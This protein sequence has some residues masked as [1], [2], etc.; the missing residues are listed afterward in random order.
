MPRN[1]AIVLAAGKGTRM[2]SDLPKVL[3][4]VRGRPMIEYVLDALTAGG[5]EQIIVV[6]GYRA[7]LVRSRLQDRKAV[8]FV[9]QSEQL[10]TGH[11]VMACHQQ[12]SSHQGPVLIVTGDSP[13]MRAETVA[14]LLAE[15]RRRPVACL[16]GT[17][18]K[19]DP[20]GLGRVIRDAK[21]EFVGIVEEGDASDDQRRIT[22]VHMSYYVFNPPD[23][24]QALDHIRRDNVQGEYYL[25]D[26]PGVLVEQGRPVRA[27]S[28]LEPEESLGVNTLEE[29][30]AVEAAMSNRAARIAE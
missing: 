4:E 3:V 19:Q 2:D 12:L 1:L 27:V 30:S 18:Y 14:A 11:A 10:G 24:L 26:C 5:A 15:F 16:L 23:L 28:V 22:E 29:L 6:V 9:V 21:G 20:T 8:Q 7:E 13:M 25:T 17:T